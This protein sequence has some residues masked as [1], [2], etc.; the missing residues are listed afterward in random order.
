MGELSTVG[1]LVQSSL[2]QLLFI[3]K[4]LFA[5]SYKT[6]Y[7]NWEFDCTDPP[8]KLVFPG[9]SDSNLDLSQALVLVHIAT[10]SFRTQPLRC[11]LL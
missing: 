4:I 6:S 9:S 10:F 5:F 8:P 1:L 2:V 7:L 11:S 3:L